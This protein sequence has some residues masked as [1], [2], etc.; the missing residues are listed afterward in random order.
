MAKDGNEG[1]RDD[2]PVTAA[3]SVA[4]ELLALIMGELAPGAS[5]PSEGDLAER[6]DVSRLTVREAVKMLAGRGLLE[7]ARGRRAVVREPDGSAFGDFLA[8]L[9]QYDPKGLFDLIEV[10][11]A[12]ELQSVSLAAKKA[13]RAGLAAIESTIEAMRLAAI[14]MR[15]GADP[16][17]AERRY[18]DADVGFH[19]ALALASGNRILT[20]LFEAMASPLQESFYLTRRGHQLRGHAP[21]HTIAAHQTILK[22]V[23]QGD[24]RGAAEAMR[25]HLED[26]ERDIRIALGSR[27]G[28]RG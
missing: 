5:L 22:F 28:P 9:I 26:A 12:L 2:A 15:A 20:Y 21:E 24:G 25:T 11:T 13:S 4:D 8:Q 19:E 27:T 7:L 1:S 3:S 6:Y 10:R 23:R 18:H 14:D 16:E 17:A